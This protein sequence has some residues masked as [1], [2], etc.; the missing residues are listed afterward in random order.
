MLNVSLR[1]EFLCVKK[2]SAL[3]Y[4]SKQAVTYNS[5]GF[6]NNI[7]ALPAYYLLYNPIIRACYFIYTR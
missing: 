6:N 3:S 1:I 7:S 5:T 4:L 2:F